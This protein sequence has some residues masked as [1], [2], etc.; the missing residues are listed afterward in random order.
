MTRNKSHRGTIFMEEAEILS[1]QAFEGEQFILRVRAPECA[2]KALPGSFVH[3]QC[4]RSK[5]LRRPIS[6]MRVSAKAGWV[7]FLYKAV[8]EGTRLLS[9][10]KPGEFLSMLGPIGVPFKLNPERPRPLLIGGGVGIPPMIFI[11]ETVANNKIYKPM[12]ILG[13]EVPFPFKP[14]P[15]SILIPEMPEGVIASMPL[16]DDWHIP[17]RLASLQGFPG[18]FEGYVTDL[19]R[20]W[21]N[22]L[23]AEARAEV[24]IFSCGPHPMLEGV[25][26]LAAEFDLPC[27]VSLEEFMACGV[28]GCAGC[29]VEVETDTGPAMKRVCVDGPVFDSRAVFSS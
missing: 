1:H 19:A 12:V 3:I 10:R 9:K 2:E 21:L 8:G 16:M 6:I 26:K 5:P 28:G 24:E 18:C 27:Q 25:A 29:V 22:A 4:D 13:S 20:H 11:A 15:S 7:D 14:H 23:P 17:N